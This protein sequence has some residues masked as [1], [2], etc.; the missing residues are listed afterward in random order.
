MTAAE[1]EPEEPQG[2]VLER[3]GKTLIL[4]ASIAFVTLIAFGLLAA[5]ATGGAYEPYYSFTQLTTSLAPFLGLAIVALIA[6]TVALVASK[7][8]R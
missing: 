3:L 5:S 1:A 2:S 4:F 6:G 7:V 8:W